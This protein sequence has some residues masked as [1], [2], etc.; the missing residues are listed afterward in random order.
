MVHSVRKKSRGRGA[1]PQTA[2][3]AT[4]GSLEKIPWWHLLLVAALAFAC[5]AQT[6]RYGFVYDDDL[7][8]VRNP[9]IRSFSSVGP[10][11]GENFWAFKSPDYFTNYYR[12]LHTVT[13]MFGYALGGL[14]PAPFH[15]INVCL[16][17]LASLAVYWLGWVLFERA[18]IALWGG[19][20]F[21]AHPMHTENVAWI[22]GVTDLG[23]G[24]FFFV[25]LAS[26]VRCRSGGDHARIWLGASLL[27]F[28]AALLFKEMALTLPFLVVVLDLAALPEARRASGASRLKAWASFGLVLLLYLALRIHALG[29]FSRTQTPIPLTK[30]DR[31]LTTLL[32]VGRYLQK[33]IIPVGHN[34]YYVFRPFLN[35]APAQW[36]PPLLT[37]LAT[38]AF[39]CLCLR[40]EKKL[41]FLAGWMVI[42][43]APV[44]SFGSVGQ[45]VFTER[46]LY[47]PSFG[48][49]LLVPAL[50]DRYLR[51]HAR[52]PAVYVACGALAVLAFLTLRRN[53]VWRDNQALYKATIEASPD[54]AQMHNNL[55]V[56][57][58]HEGNLP[59]AREEFQAALDA[60]AR[61]FNPYDRD[62]Y[63]SLLGLG[64][65]HYVEGEAADA[66]NCAEAAVKLR[67]DLPD[68]YQ[69]LGAVMGGLG[70]YSEAEKL[71]RRALEID[72]LD[73]MARLNMGN[74]HIIRGNL[75]AAEIEFRKAIDADPRSPDP[76]V[77][78]A[79]LFDRMNR[80]SEAIYVLREVLAMDPHN[81]PALRLLQ[82]ISSDP[83][84]R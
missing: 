47:I 22:A 37:L 36:I 13:Y 64:G 1:G 59:A 39:V 58:Y 11:F 40:K 26:Y 50:A 24:L 23:C 80:S 84:R 44:L 48:L 34:A 29:V 32:F 31:L 67:P 79:A 76:R 74:I 18:R 57:Y 83:P 3:G 55:G 71:L 66:V 7:Q 54:A 65:L 6:V 72:P 28:L 17:A 35:L 53:P 10:A 70:R 63:A 77:A 43:L 42:T 45:N 73:P 9:R 25:S 68:A 38:S 20:L 33:L 15:A 2:T 46:Y 81:P 4:F 8:L 62:R 16:H 5:Y 27:S 30:L 52:K 41:L 49:C 14:S 19:L 69:A 82:Q 75:A 60:N 61:A 12:P 21:A 78:L 56:A 51:G